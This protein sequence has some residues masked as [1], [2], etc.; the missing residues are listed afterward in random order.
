MPRKCGNMVWF[1]MVPV[2]LLT[3]IGVCLPEM[4][5]L[6]WCC[7]AGLLCV[8]TGFVVTELTILWTKW[9]EEARKDGAIK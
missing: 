6:E 4:P 7:C 1:L 3:A 9:S 8:S 2:C 5:L